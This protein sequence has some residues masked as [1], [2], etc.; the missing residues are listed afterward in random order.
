MKNKKEVQ[1]LVENIRLLCD[2]RNSISNPTKALILHN[3]IKV[4]LT[5][6]KKLIDKQPDCDSTF[7]ELREALRHSTI[8]ENNA[9]ST[10]GSLQ[11][12]LQE[13]SILLDTAKK[14]IKDQET[15]IINLHDLKE[16]LCTK[17]HRTEKATRDLQEK[18]YA[19]NTAQVDLHQKIQADKI[20]IRNL[21]TQFESAAHQNYCTICGNL[22]DGYV[23]PKPKPSPEEVVQ[24]LC[25]Q[26]NT[27]KSQRHIRNALL[28][29]IK[30]M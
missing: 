24:Y 14:L 1:E 28:Q 26:I 11:S 8:R 23:P 6:L 18:L 17:L 2:A 10:I 30:D 4:H 13:K 21:R 3:T 25:D 22:L 20:A 9:R 12:L 19:A 7:K 5:E 15:T 27:E 16:S 29:I